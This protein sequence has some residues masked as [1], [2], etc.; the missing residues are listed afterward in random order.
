MWYADWMSKTPWCVSHV[1]VQLL[2]NNRFRGIFFFTFGKKGVTASATVHSSLQAYWK[3]KQQKRQPKIR[4]LWEIYTQDGWGEQLIYLSKNSPWSRWRR[5]REATL[6]D[7]LFFP[8]SFYENRWKG[9]RK[10]LLTPQD[11]DHAAVVRRLPS[12][13]SFPMC[14]LLSNVEYIAIIIYN[15]LVAKNKKE[16]HQQRERCVIVFELNTR[17]SN[18]LRS[19]PRQMK[20]RKPCRSY[21]YKYIST[22]WV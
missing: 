18:P 6:I 2:F 10:P 14:W 20:R 12:Y 19:S 11:L 4:K 17:P 3:Y 5:Q 15:G 1:Q 21:K 7:S 22:S 8:H 9:D 13:S 16:F